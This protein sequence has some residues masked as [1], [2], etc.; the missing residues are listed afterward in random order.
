MSGV[1]PVNCGVLIV[2]YVEMSIPHVERKPSFLYP[3]IL[4]LY[5]HYDCFIGEEEDLLT[6]AVGEVVYKLGPEA[7]AAETGT[8]DS[9]DPAVPEASSLPHSELPK[10]RFLTTTS[11]SLGSRTQV[12]G[13]LERR[14]PFRLGLSGSPLQADPR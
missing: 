10:S 1:R 8:E 12:G 13:T 2:E 9:S 14:G 5:Q 4:H 7:E 6:I 3:Y 11:T